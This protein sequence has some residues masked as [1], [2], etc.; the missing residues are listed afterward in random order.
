MGDTFIHIAAENIDEEAIEQILRE[1]GLFEYQMLVLERIRDFL[2]YALRSGEKGISEFAF[3]V[4]SWGLTKSFIGRVL[5]RIIPQEEEFSKLK[6]V[7]LHTKNMLFEVSRI[8]ED[9]GNLVSAFTLYFRNLVDLYGWP[10]I[11]FIDDLESVLSYRRLVREMN[12]DYAVGFAEFL[13]CMINK[14]ERT[15]IDVRG[16]VHFILAATPPVYQRFHDVLQEYLFSGWIER[17]EILSF[18]LRPILRTEFFRLM[19]WLS[20]KYLGGDPNGIFGDKRL[21]E[22]IYT[23]TMGNPGAIIQQFLRYYGGKNPRSLKEIWA[24]LRAETILS[25]EQKAVPLFSDTPMLLEDSLLF[26]VI[27]TSAIYEDEPWYEDLKLLKE[28]L[29]K[30]YLIKLSWGEAYIFEDLRALSEIIDELAR[31][32]VPADNPDVIYSFKIALCFFMHWHPKGYSFILPDSV[33]DMAFFFQRLDMERLQDILLKGVM[34][35][36]KEILRKKAKS[37]MRAVYLSPS[38]YPRIYPAYSVAVIPF[39]MSGESSE[40]FNNVM[41]ISTRDPTRFSELVAN[42]FID[43]IRRG[44][45]GVE[46]KA[47]EIYIFVP[48][49]RSSMRI[50]Y[51]IPVEIH[52]VVG[53]PKLIIDKI[54]ENYNELK[55]YIILAPDRA[56]VPRKK[57]NMLVFEMTLRDLVYLAAKSYVENNPKYR[58]SLITEKW[59]EFALSILSRYHVVERIE[60]WIDRGIDAGVILPPEP[61]HSRMLETRRTKG[62]VVFFSRYRLLLVGGNNFTLDEL[63]D[64]L[65]KIYSS[66]PFGRDTWCDVKIP[67]VLPEDIEP[68]TI[69]GSIDKQKFFEEAKSTITPALNIAVANHMATISGDGR[70]TLELHPAEKR[71][72]RILRKYSGRIHRDDLKSLFIFLTRGNRSETRLLDNLVDLLSYRGLI[73]TGSRKTITLIQDPLSR[74]QEAEGLYLEFKEH[75]KNLI[76]LLSR[77]SI[78]PELRSIENGLLHI[79][80]A[81]KKGWKL[82][83]LKDIVDAIE[84]LRKRYLR[85]RAS[86]ILVIFKDYLGLASRMLSYIRGAVESM[87]SIVNETGNILRSLNNIRQQIRGELSRILGSDFDLPDSIVESWEDRIRRLSL[88]INEFPKVMTARRILSDARSLLGQRYSE[89]REIWDEFM[90]NKGCGSDTKFNLALLIINREFETLVGMSK[91][92]T[93]KLSQILSLLKAI[94][95]KLQQIPDSEMVT[96]YKKHIEGAI[97]NAGSLSG[98]IDILKSTLRRLENEVRRIEEI[99]ELQREKHQIKRTLEEILG[100]A[101]DA[102]RRIKEYLKIIGSLGDVLGMYIGVLNNVGSVVRGI[103]ESLTTIS[104]RLSTMPLSRNT[105]EGIKEDLI[106]IMSQ[107]NSVKTKLDSICR[108]VGEEIRRAYL[109]SL[110]NQIEVFRGQIGDIGI[111]NDI[112]TLITD[113]KHLEEELQRVDMER[114]PQIIKQIESLKERWI[115]I[116][117]EC[118][119][120]LSKTK[121]ITSKHVMVLEFLL[122]KLSNKEVTLREAVDLISKE[123]AVDKKEALQMIYELEMRGMLK[124][125]LRIQKFP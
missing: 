8:F 47:H 18:R 4:G 28:K 16:K 85:C 56:S 36:A 39:V 70:I 120:Y 69:F 55:M 122:A 97:K 58:E 103:K 64:I 71:I 83:M 65:F 22:H 117:E 109:G 118:V 87:I 99:S 13:R 32:V 125:F 3:I 5:E 46:T 54:E 121:Q 114:I 12:V 73:K 29:E 52:V 44:T 42:A 90:F 6:Y 92:Y 50:G 14:S 2:R 104:T 34:K 115:K 10:L 96:S 38:S 26:L 74:E 76:D 63:L 20:R 59:E 79:L 24:K 77:L 102:E 107:I 116:R 95:V 43:V 30:E 27:S 81:K 78:A 48:R 88:R 89:A 17:R 84:S 60:S 1:F 113:I 93:G 67:A 37:T 57:W 31:Y 19:D 106:Q 123:F 35:H 61:K 100:E 101:E 68:T 41:E 25:S 72:L 33:D 94:N 111:L 124:V 98:V 108:S 21:L 80:V 9:V 112:V 51:R 75:V 66:R 53:D 62:D 86:S 45:L 15:C 40:V 110:I 23:L 49:E 82:I 7:R 91:E 119:D 11:V 105:I